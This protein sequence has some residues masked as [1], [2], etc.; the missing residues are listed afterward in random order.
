[1]IGGYEMLL[2]GTDPRDWDLSDFHR[3]PTEGSQ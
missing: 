2:R 1:M 3:A